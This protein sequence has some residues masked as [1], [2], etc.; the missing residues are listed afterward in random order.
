MQDKGFP[1]A[2]AGICREVGERGWQRVILLGQDLRE[3]PYSLRACLA[4]SGVLVLSPGPRDREWL[5]AISAGEDASEATAVRFAA[6]LADGL[7]H[8]VQAVLVT[9][10]FLVRLVRASGLEVPLLAVGE[11]RA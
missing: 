7:E 11:A 4:Q 1:E 10:A 3:G 6:M 9:D 8:G 2:F 5:D